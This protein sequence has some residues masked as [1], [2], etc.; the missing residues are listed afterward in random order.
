MPARRL[1]SL[2]LP[3]LASDLALR[4]RPVAGAFALI[5]RQASADRLVCLNRAAEQAGLTN[6]IGLADARALCPD[7]VTALHDPAAQAQGLGALLRWARRYSPW[8]ALDGPDG[9]VL[10][11]TGAAHLFG[12]EGGVLA[13]LSGRLARMGLGARMAIAGTRGAAWAVAR[14][15]A[16]GIVPAGGE[17]RALNPLPL[18]ALRLPPDTLDALERLG[19][20]IIR[21]LAQIPRATLPRR[22]GSEV[23]LRLDQALGHVA[24]PV[25][26]APLPPHF[27]VRLSLP[28]PIGLQ[29]DLQAGLVR[30]LDRLCEH[31][32]R[33]EQGA[34]RLTLTLSRVDGQALVLDISLAR[35]MRDASAM[36][37]LFARGLDSVDAGFG[38]DAL[39]LTAPVTESLPVQ[40]ISTE[41]AAGA[42]D[43]ADLLTRLTNR[44]G[45]EHVLRLLPA[46]SHIPEKAAILAPA[47]YSEPHGH[48]PATRLRPVDLFDPEPLQGARG[49]QPPRAFR[50]RG[51]DWQVVGVTGPERIT[52]EWWLDDPAWRTG[53]R[54]YWCVQ[55]AQGAR[56]WLFHV[57]ATDGWSV[58]GMFA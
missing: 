52:P 13:D 49:P 9:L 33:A 25:S 47:A 45:F 12:G 6:G 29:A 30:L 40:Q 1:L 56:L 54:D 46:D 42:D 23:L 8:V 43:L 4:R 2:W 24:E 37:N 10:D 38:I 22:F 7:L 36:A 50:W 48:W 11:L 26:P 5:A 14:L 55:T 15:G 21:D 57:P 31:L 53:L 3:R 51:Q 18:A 32:H 28:D 20:R 17:A 44:L 41:G 58:Q 19:L 34:R 16:G 27:G 39:R 35:P